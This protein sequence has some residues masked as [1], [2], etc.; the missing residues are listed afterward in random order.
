MPTLLD[1]PRRRAVEAVV[2][3]RRKVDDAEVERVA[4]AHGL[5][6]RALAALESGSDAHLARDG[7]VVRDDVRE[8]ALLRHRRVCAFAV[9]RRTCALCARVDAR[10]GGARILGDRRARARRSG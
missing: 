1:N 8:R 5:H 10:R 3:A 6:R 2:V 9:L 4:R 7:R